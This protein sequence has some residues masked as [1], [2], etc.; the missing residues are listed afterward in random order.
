ME[1]IAIVGKNSYAIEI[2]Q[3]RAFRLISGLLLVGMRLSVK[4]VWVL[5]IFGIIKNDKS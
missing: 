5:Y 3:R 1:P 2:A 4:N